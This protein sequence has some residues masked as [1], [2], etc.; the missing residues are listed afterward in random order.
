VKK[1]KVVRIRWGIKDSRGL[2]STEDL[3][4]LLY[5]RKRTA[6]CYC[7]PGSTERPVKL[8]VTVEEL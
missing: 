1:Q 5:K 2:V 4:H 6:R 8:R 3:S 7:E